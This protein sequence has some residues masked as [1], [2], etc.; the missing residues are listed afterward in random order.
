MSFIGDLFGGGDSGPPAPVIPDSTPTVAPVASPVAATPVLSDAASVS[1]AM[2]Q[3][4]RLKKRYGQP[5]TILTSG[6]GDSS[7]G[8]AADVTRTTALGGGAAPS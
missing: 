8:G 3:A 4:T 1:A 2:E 6:L 7:S 5:D